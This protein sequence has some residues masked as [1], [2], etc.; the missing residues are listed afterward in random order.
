MRL[1]LRV[2]A[3]LFGAMVFLVA[4]SVVIELLTGRP[5]PAISSL[6][7]LIGGAI[8]WMLVG[9]KKPADD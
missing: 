7:G 3:W 5:R 9:K 2:L 1:F 6:F 4:S 8:G